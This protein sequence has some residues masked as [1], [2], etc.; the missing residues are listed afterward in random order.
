LQ[1]P[2]AAAK[3]PEEF[4]SIAFGRRETWEAFAD[5]KSGAEDQLT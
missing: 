5:F 2:K 4:P 1:R 3:P